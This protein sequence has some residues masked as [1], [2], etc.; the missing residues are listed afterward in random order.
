MDFN[1]EW[2]HF[3]SILLKRFALLEIKNANA[4]SYACFKALPQ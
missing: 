2:N 1:E 4:G 3:I